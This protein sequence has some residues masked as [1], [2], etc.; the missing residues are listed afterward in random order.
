MYD[1]LLVGITCLCFLSSG[2]HAEECKEAILAK[3]NTVYASAGDSLSLLCVVQHCGDTWTGEWMWRNSTD[4]NERVVKDGARHQLTN[5]SLSANETQLLLRL[6]SVNKSDEGYYRCKGTWDQGKTHQ[7]HFT[8]VNITAA[9]P[10][11]RSVLHRSLV[12]TGA[13]LCLPIILILARCLSSFPRTRSTRAAEPTAA[14]RALPH[15]AP[16]PPPRCPV[17]QKRSTSS[18]KVPPK[19]QQN[20]E[21][22]YAD[23]SKDALSQQHQATRASSQPTVYSSVNFQSRGKKDVC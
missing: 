15:P 19:P 5:K 16:Q 7:G 12:C 14:Y 11:Q 20:T 9:G 3:R 6:L 13:F 8:Y 23:I 21:V 17:P 4:N 18:H 2:F 22:V 1:Y 10:S